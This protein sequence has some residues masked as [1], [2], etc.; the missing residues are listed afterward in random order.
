MEEVC[1]RQESTMKEEK[2]RTT[3]KLIF[4]SPGEMYEEEQGGMEDG[5]GERSVAET[6]RKK[7][8]TGFWRRH[9]GPGLNWLW[10]RVGLGLGIGRGLGLGTV[11]SREDGVRRTR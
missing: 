5:P 1:S 2:E 8:T 10:L 3:T 4:F 7:R 11:V 6:R 9:W